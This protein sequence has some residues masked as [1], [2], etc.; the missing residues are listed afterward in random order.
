MKDF[1]IYIFQAALCQGVFLLVYLFLLRGNTFFRFNRVFLLL[2]IFISILIPTVNV[3]YDVVVQPIS[4]LAT[5]IDKTPLPIE[6]N[7]V[8]FWTMLGV[9]YILGALIV[10]MKNVFACIKLKK[11]ASNSETVLYTNGTKIVDSKKIATPFSFFKTVYINTDNM[12]EKEK[13]IIF[14][15][16]ISHIKDKHWVDLFCSECALVLQWFNPLMWYYIHLLKENHEYLADQAVVGSGESV[17][18][19]RAVLINQR[20]QGP[21]FSF[22]NSFNYSKHQNRLAMMKKVKTSPWK[23]VAA[24]AVLPFMGAFLMLNAKPNYVYESVENKTRIVSDSIDKSKVIV[25]G[26]GSNVKDSLIPVDSSASG[27]TVVSKGIDSSNPPLI[28]LDNNEITSEEMNKIDPNDILNISVLKDKTAIKMYGEK[29]KNGVI[30]ITSK[31]KDKNRKQDINIL[32]KDILVILD[33]VEMTSEEFNKIDQSSIV[34]VDVIKDKELLKPYGEKGK[35][36]VM[37]ITTQK[38]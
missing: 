35:N 6:T 18:V 10:L 15:H 8:D 4:L 13:D 26:Y 31:A 20:F 3:S 24:I 29:G 28:F 33:G 27:N 22:T 5:N 19:Y 38:E 32:N 2:G 16:E 12:Q 1:F 21:V 14:K 30:L 25:V 37:I 7:V 17:A 34:K 23:K 36:G 11:L 9:V